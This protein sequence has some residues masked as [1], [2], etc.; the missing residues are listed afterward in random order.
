MINKNS[1][2]D[3]YLA[4]SGSE[5]SHIGMLVAVLAFLHYPSKMDD[6]FEFKNNCEQIYVLSVIT[7]ALGIFVIIMMRWR[8]FKA[9]YI[10]QMVHVCQ[11]LFNIYLVNITV[12]AYTLF[13]EFDE[14]RADNEKL[15]YLPAHPCKFNLCQMILYITVVL[16]CF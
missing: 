12:D 7:H 9:S 14:K 16:I 8:P 11:V 10:G 5:L 2:M 15:T 13:L 4:L 3:A 6:D 1:L